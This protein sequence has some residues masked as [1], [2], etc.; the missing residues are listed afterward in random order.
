MPQETRVPSVFATANVS[1]TSALTEEQLQTE[2]SGMAVTRSKPTASSD[3]VQAGLFNLMMKF[4]NLTY[5]TSQGVGALAMNF[6][7]RGTTDTGLVARDTATLK[8]FKDQGLYIG[9]EDATK[10]TFKGKKFVAVLSKLAGDDRKIK[11]I[12]EDEFS[13]KSNILCPIGSFATPEA[14]IAHFSDIMTSNVKKLQLAKLV[15][16][17]LEIVEPNPKTHVKVTIEKILSNDPTKPTTDEAKELVKFIGKQFAG[18]A[19][20]LG[21]IDGVTLTAPIGQ[22]KEVQVA[23]NGKPVYAPQVELYKA[24]VFDFVTGELVAEG[25]LDSKDL[26]NTMALPVSYKSISSEYLEKNEALLA[27]AKTSNLPI[28]G[29]HKA[30]FEHILQFDIKKSFE[31]IGEN[32]IMQIN[33]DAVCL[34]GKGYDEASADQKLTRCLF[35]F[36]GE[37]VKLDTLS[38]ATKKAVG[39]FSDPEK[40]EAIK[41]KIAADD[42]ATLKGALLDKEY[43]RITKLFPALAI[44]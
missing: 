29:V 39:H 17:T 43:F 14:V 38:D 35:N 40:L 20:P 18:L 10:T 30:D 8:W 24:R 5:A 7:H 34:K 37:V 25:V 6:N 9:A 41:S 28:F 19:F 2:F 21:T 4:A 32:L 13:P 1:F 36:R 33:L 22:P 16:D 42:L 3:D 44:K 26:F 23:Y 27:Q 12:T 11:T 31:T 15:K